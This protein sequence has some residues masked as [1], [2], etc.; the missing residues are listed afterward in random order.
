MRHA[1]AARTDRLR[2]IA[3]LAVVAAL[4]AA[5]CASD[6]AVPAPGSDVAESVISTVEERLGSVA[7]PEPE[8]LPEGC[9]IEQTEDEYGFPV[10]VVVCDGEEPDEPDPGEQIR[11]VDWA[12][13]DAADEV[14]LLIRNA[15][16]IGGGCGDD[17]LIRDLEIAVAEAPQRVRDELEAVAAELARAATFCT[18][19]P[20]RWEAHLRLA[21]ASL[22]VF[23]RVAD[24]A[25]V[26]RI[27]E[28][29][30][31]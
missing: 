4:F 7:E 29:T 19:D 15:L 2:R 28:L 27:Q 24:A 6:D 9:R 13:S 17:E 5:G 12:G 21:I 16:V 1:T 30:D 10:D 11:F 31:E 18:T 25:R 22:E 14:A 3:V 23:V 8:E 26:D 20:E